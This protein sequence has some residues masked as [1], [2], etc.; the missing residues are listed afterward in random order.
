MWYKLIQRII[1]SVDF[2]MI[3]SRTMYWNRFN[4]NWWYYIVLLFFKQ[5]GGR[6]FINY[7]PNFF[8]IDVFKYIV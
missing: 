3:L 1:I 2:V 5:A 4:P 8:N 7:I 6:Y